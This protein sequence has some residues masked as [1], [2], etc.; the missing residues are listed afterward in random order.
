MK[1]IFFCEALADFQIASDLIDRVLREGDQTWV[2]DV[3]AATP[4]GIRTFY[5]D[6]NRPF[7]DV[8]S[9]RRYVDDLSV[10]VPHGH[11]DGRPGAADAVMGRTVFAIVRAL[12][13]KGDAVDAAI[14]IRDIDNKPSRQAGLEQSRAEA[15]KLGRFRIVLGCPNIMREAWVLVGFEAGDTDEQ[16]RLANMRQ[17]LGFSPTENAHQL[18]SGDEQAKRSPKRVLRALTLG[19]RAREEKCWRETPL[20][21]LRTRCPPTGLC[22]FLLEVE[23]QLVPLCAQE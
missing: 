2:A 1:L 20:D 6:G 18:D 14:I 10:R 22:A 7:F 11:F 21:I 13:Q 15:A 19:D 16:S 5:A 12:V 17:E 4:D 9:L 3:M 8:H 23:Q